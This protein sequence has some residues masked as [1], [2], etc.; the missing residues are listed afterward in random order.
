MIVCIVVI[1]GLGIGRF[2]EKF[3]LVFVSLCGV[4]FVGLFVWIIDIVKILC[5]FDVLIFIVI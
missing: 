2:V 1:Y 3:G 5:D 4:M